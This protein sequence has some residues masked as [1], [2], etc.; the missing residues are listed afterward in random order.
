MRPD[1]LKLYHQVTI[2]QVCYHT[3]LG[4]ST[5]EPILDQIRFVDIFYS[6][7][8]FSDGSCKGIQSHRT[9]VKLLDDRHEDIPVDMI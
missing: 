3:T 2:S 9:T 4:C 5:Q 1:F 8:I 7:G 6:A